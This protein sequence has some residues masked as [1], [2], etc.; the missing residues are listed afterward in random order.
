MMSLFVRYWNGLPLQNHVVIAPRRIYPDN[1]FL[2]PWKLDLRNVGAENAVSLERDSY[3]S[4][5]FLSDTD[6]YH[7]FEYVWF[8]S[9]ATSN[10]PLMMTLAWSFVQKHTLWFLHN[11]LASVMWHWVARSDL[12]R[13]YA[14]RMETRSYREIAPRDFRGNDTLN[15]S[16][17]RYS[18]RRILVVTA[19]ISCASSETTQTLATLIATWSNFYVRLS[20]EISWCA[21]PTTLQSSKRDS[22]YFC[23]AIRVSARRFTGYG[24]S[25]AQFWRNLH[26]RQFFTAPHSQ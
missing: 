8:F 22:R 20:L 19:K 18:A 25:I 15:R 13:I 12:T 24:K 1:S 16:L 5:I 4:R 10:V 3:V 7:W 26:L 17:T 9:T 6:F 2:Q 14:T 23:V 11:H 21:I